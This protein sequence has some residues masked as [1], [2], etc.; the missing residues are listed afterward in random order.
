MKRGGGR[1]RTTVGV[2]VVVV[3]GCLGAALASQTT[4][5][6]T[7]LG[8]GETRGK[9]S[10]LGF[11]SR[12]DAVVGLFELPDDFQAAF[13]EL[14]RWGYRSLRDLGDEYAASLGQDEDVG[15]EHG[16]I[17]PVSPTEDGS[18][19][20]HGVYIS[21]D[22]GRNATLLRIK[23]YVESLNNENDKNT[24]RSEKDEL[25]WQALYDEGATQPPQLATDGYIQNITRAIENEE[26]I[27]EALEAR[28]R[29]GGRAD[30]AS[31]V[32]GGASNVNGAVV[33]NI[34]SVSFCWKD[35][36]G[37]GV[38][39]TPFH[40]PEGMETINGGVFC[41]DKCAKFGPHWYRP[42]GLYDCHQQCPSHMADHGLLCHSANRG[43]G[44]GKIH[45]GW[46]EWASAE[47]GQGASRRGRRLLGG[48]KTKLVCGGQH[49]K[50][51]DQQDCLGLCYDP[52]PNTHPT[53]I[54]CNLCGVS[55]SDF[56]PGSIPPSCMKRIIYSPGFPTRATCPPD[57]E[58]DAGLCYKRCKPGFS[59]V[60]PVCWGFAPRVN[61]QQWVDCGMG[62][63]V[64]N[65]AC[66]SAVTNQVLGPLEVL[67]FV[68]TFG[69]SAAAEQGAESIARGSAA[70]AKAGSKRAAAKAAAKSLNSGLE[71]ASSAT[72]YY[73]ALANMD[74]AQTETEALRASLELLAV[75]EPTGVVGTALAYA[76]DTCDKIHGAGEPAATPGVPAPVT[77]PGNWFLAND[78]VCYEICQN[79]RNVCGDRI[80]HDPVTRKCDY[81]GIPDYCQASSKR[82]DTSRNR[83]GA[84]KCCPSGK[85]DA[86]PNGEC[87]DECKNTVTHCGDQVPYD[88][89]GVCMYQSSPFC[90]NQNC[91]GAHNAPNSGSCCDSG[92]THARSWNR[93]H[94]MVCKENCFNT[95]SWCAMDIRHEITGEPWIE[96]CSYSGRGEF[97][98]NEECSTAEGASKPGLH[99]RWDL[100]PMVNGKHGRDSAVELRLRANEEGEFEEEE[101]EEG[102]GEDVLDIAAPFPP[103]PP[104]PSPPPPS[105]PPPSA[106]PSPPPSPPPPS[107]PPQPDAPSA[108]EE[109]E[110]FE[111]EEDEGR[112][113]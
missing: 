67:A 107:K 41:Y 61:G 80:A 97:C 21:T 77:C 13:D 102:E 104:P 100:C 63:A 57:M 58:M 47:L 76:F 3:V 12:R 79:T 72:G 66:G 83:P 103:F 54:G 73:Q 99:P 37:R 27:I 65:A 110:F 64:D 81:G 22:G 101:E 42:D 94:Y 39:R 15:F 48:T 84:S 38:G 82:C 75:V 96:K 16:A 17:E 106:P 30:A 35:S 11:P 71:H 74:N 1:W 60:G 109:G 68:A 26:E 5:T 2:C 51:R 19:S 69:T 86:G 91:N 7:T 34:V 33:S 113:R 29:L 70:V 36:Y 44:V 52:C 25:E 43:R 105:P 53:W 45:C 10:R 55:C 14:E 78:G 108:E 90:E 18:E 56:Q 92:Y 46:E 98:I 88:S 50:N 32:I 31:D 24:L 62:A 85:V 9:G 4:T 59:A 112:R 28:A 40:C 93:Q 23:A 20:G 111:E 87:Y 6:T 95:D 49:C 8:S 89:N